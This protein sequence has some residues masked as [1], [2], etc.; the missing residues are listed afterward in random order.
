MEAHRIFAALMRYQIDSGFACL[1]E[2]SLKTGRRPD[3]CCLGKDGK[4]ILIEVKSSIAD[5]KSDNK[6]HEYCEWAD[7][8][9]FAVG[10][11][12]PLELLPEA[13]QCGIFITD[14]F[15]VHL[16][17]RAPHKKLAAAR[18]HHL[19]RRLA[20]TAMMRHYIASLPD[21]ARIRSQALDE[22]ED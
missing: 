19:T 12:F 22:M 8:F 3:I 4:I 20:R 15:D 21:E 13:E 5:F 14:G 17:R 18:R 7:E 9:Y 1:P 11:D 6:W 16:F 2:F 10:D